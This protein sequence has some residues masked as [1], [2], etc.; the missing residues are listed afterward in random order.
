MIAFSLSDAGSA[1]LDP[2]YAQIVVVINASPSTQ[3]VGDLS[4]AH[5]GF[6]LHPVQAASVDP[7]LKT[8]KYDVTGT[9]TVP[10]RTTAVFVVTRAR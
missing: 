9:F 3:T 2:N 4:F 6:T 8:A 5:A 10:A 7:L 1:A